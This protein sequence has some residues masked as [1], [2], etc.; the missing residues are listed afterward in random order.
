MKLKIL[1]GHRLEQPELA[2]MMPWGE[3]VYQEVM[4]PCWRDEA[5]K[6]PDFSSLVAKLGG[7]LGDEEVSAYEELSQGYKERQE[8]RSRRPTP[9]MRMD[10]LVETV[11]TAFPGEG[12]IA[13]E[14][15]T[16][17]SATFEPGYS[18]V[19]PGPVEGGYIGLQQM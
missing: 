15:V 2:E 8:E 5:R 1:S 6:R 4:L 7:L 3:E 17:P 11:S 18:V 12:Y 9:P 13:M 16:A 10:S 14:E 19:T